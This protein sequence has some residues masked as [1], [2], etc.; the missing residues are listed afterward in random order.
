MSEGDR[1]LGG[2]HRRIDVAEGA[3]H[4]QYWIASR[5]AAAVKLSVLMMRGTLSDIDAPM[6]TAEL[7]DLL[8]DIEMADVAGVRLLIA[9]HASKNS[10][11][12][13]SISSSVDNRVD[14]PSIERFR[15][16]NAS[17]CARMLRHRDHDRQALAPAQRRSD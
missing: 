13:F 12:C 5:G 14:R 15:F 2:S 10:I 17:R 4:H 6:R 8:P 9:D 16:Q 7:I 3:T 1:S 11:P